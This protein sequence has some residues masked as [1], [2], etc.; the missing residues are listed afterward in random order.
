LDIRH[1]VFSVL[2]PIWRIAALSDYKNPAIRIVQE[3][4]TNKIFRFK[5]ISNPNKFF[6]YFGIYFSLSNS[7]HSHLV[8]N[9]WFIIS[10]F[11]KSLKE[12]LSGSPA[13]L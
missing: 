6:R 10:F 8:G 13:L 7:I 1:V 2:S 3:V 9:F 4:Y 5:K 12:V 11:K